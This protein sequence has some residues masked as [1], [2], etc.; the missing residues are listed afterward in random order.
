MINHLI[1][2]IKLGN[3]IT[4]SL[5]NL[6]GTI[7]AYGHKSSNSS[8][9]SIWWGLGDNKANV[10]DKHWSYP[11]VTG[12]TFDASR[13]NGIYKDGCNTVQPNSLCLNHIIKY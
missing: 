2:P 6:K 3:T 4:P 10:H 9:F 12:L 13:Y 5:P 8:L 11:Y 7:S 1:F